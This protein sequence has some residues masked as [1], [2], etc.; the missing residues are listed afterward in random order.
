MELK[1]TLL[2]KLYY[3]ENKFEGRGILVPL[4]PFNIYEVKK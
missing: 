1:D 4:L 2:P 3:N